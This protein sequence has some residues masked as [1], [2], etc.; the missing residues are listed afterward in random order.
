MGPWELAPWVSQHWDPLLEKRTTIKGDEDLNALG[1]AVANSPAEVFPARPG[2]PGV[3]AA[4][5]PS[6]SPRLPNPREEGPHY[7]VDADLGLHI[8]QALLQDGDEGGRR[9]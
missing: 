7:L 9:H 6:C 5:P 1:E 2:S 8:L 3:G 4:G